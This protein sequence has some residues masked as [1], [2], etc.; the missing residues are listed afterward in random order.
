M[1]VHSAS[2]VNDV[3]SN[4]SSVLVRA[5]SYLAADA[6]HDQLHIS[7]VDSGNNRA[8]IFRS[9]LFFPFGVRFHRTRIAGIHGAQDVRVGIGTAYF[10]TPCA[11]GKPIAWI[12]PNTIYNPRAPVNLLC[13]NKFHYGN[14]G[15]RS[16]HKIDLLERKR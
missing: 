12:F 9:L 13:V 11:G 6:P 4:A 2:E 1:H 15:G 5:H 14:K 16:G 7:I 10:V 8:H 3:V